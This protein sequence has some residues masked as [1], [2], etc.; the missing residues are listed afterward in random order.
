MSVAAG[1]PSESS[2]DAVTIQVTSGGPQV[3]NILDDTW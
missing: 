2:Y 3:F 1:Q